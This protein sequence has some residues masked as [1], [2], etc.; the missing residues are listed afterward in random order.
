MR[1]PI[2]VTIDGRTFSVNRP[3]TT[4]VATAKDGYANDQ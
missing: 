3:I 1:A 4:Q 2:A